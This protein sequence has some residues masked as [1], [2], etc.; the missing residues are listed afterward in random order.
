LGYKYD[1]FISY[2]R[3]DLTLQW[4]DKHFVP[5]L[6]LHIKNEIDIEPI[7]CIDAQ[8]ESGTTWPVALGK[9]LGASKTII[10]I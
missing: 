5:I 2:R 8:L 3:Y 10:P 9:A 1:I 4:I 6:K 7:I